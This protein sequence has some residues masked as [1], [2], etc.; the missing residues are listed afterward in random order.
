MTAAE[1]RV[2]RAVGPRRPC[3]GLTQRPCTRRPPS[4][5]SNDSVTLAASLSRK[6]IVVDLPLRKLACDSFSL[7]SAGARLVEPPPPPPPPPPDPPPVSPPPPGFWGVFLGGSAF[8]GAPSW[9]WTFTVTPADVV[10]LPSESRA[11]AVS[12][13]LPLATL[14]LPHWVE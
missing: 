2:A 8:T 9:L 5:R 3:D 13:W 12:V 1:P 10:V 7:V 4:L 6:L 11:T 14:M